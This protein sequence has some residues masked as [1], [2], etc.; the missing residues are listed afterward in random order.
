MPRRSDWGSIQK[1]GT[2]KY[3]LR[4]WAKVDGIYTRTPEAVRGTRRQAGDVLLASIAEASGQGARA[5]HAKR[6]ITT[7]RG[8]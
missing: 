3:R 8:L 5:R 1:V 7:P 6:G 4:Y 2:N